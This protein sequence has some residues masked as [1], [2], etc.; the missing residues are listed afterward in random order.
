MP[1]GLDQAFIT[2]ATDKDQKIVKRNF[3]IAIQIVF[4]FIL[5]LAFPRPECA[6]KEQKVG[7]INNPTPVKVRR[8]W[9]ISRGR[10][11]TYQ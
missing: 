1:G 8:R 9:R 6:D 3:T 2:K 5:L 7:K 10:S 4:C 11:H